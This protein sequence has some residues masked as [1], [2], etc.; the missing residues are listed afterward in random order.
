[1]LRF[2]IKS[3]VRSFKKKKGFYILNISGL[4]IG[5]AASL[6]ILLFV[7]DEMSYDKFHK[8]HERV[9]RIVKDF[10]NDDGSRLPDATTPPALSI[11]IQKDIPEIAKTTRVFP[12]WGNKF[13]IRYGEKNFIEERLWRVDSSFFDVFTFPFIAG[14][15]KKAFN[16]VNSIVITQSMSKKYFGNENAI[17]KVLKLDRLGDLMVT[18]IVNDVP[19]N[20]HFHFDFLIPVKKFNGNINSNWGFYNFYTYV[21]LKPKTRIA[22]V[23]PKIQATYQK[24]VS[25]GK[26]IFYA[27]ALDDI[28]LTSNLKWEIEPN[29]DKMYIRIFSL[30][31]LFVIIIACINY[32]N[33]TTAKSSLRA[34]EIGIR[35]VAGA[36]RLSLIKQ[37]LSESLLIVLFAFVVGIFIAQLLMPVVDQLTNK[38]LSLTTFLTVKWISIILGSVLLLG[39]TAG[40][41]PAIYLSS[42]KPVHVLKGNTVSETKVFSLRKALVVL[43]F[44]ISVVLIIGTVIIIQQVNFI[45]NAKLG[46]NKEQV[47]IIGNANYL[48]RQDLAP[49]Q[50]ELLKID[51]VKSAAV[52]DGVVGGL[53]WTT[54]MNVKG[55]QTQQLVNLLNV[56][57]D[58]LKTLGITIKQGRDFSASYPA[59]SS[60]NGIPGTTER[61][62]GSIILNEKAVKDL[63]IKEPVVGSLVSIG[64]N[65]DTTYYV[66]VVG[67]TNDFHFASFKNEIKPFAFFVDHTRYSNIT[68]KLSSGDLKRTIAGVEKTWAKFSPDKPFQYSFLDDTFGKLYASEERFN[69]VFLYVTIL[70]IFIACLGLFGLTAF[71]IERRTKEI[72]IRKI[73]GASVSGIIVLLSKDFIKL[74][75]ISFIIACPIAWYFMDQW[76]HDFVYRININAWVFVISGIVSVLIAMITI[77]FQSIRAARVNPVESLRTE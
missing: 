10:V 62:S 56:G 44:T 43:Q 26:N 41:Y 32:I 65:N 3:A 55:S 31:G 53:N 24:N 23:V 29:S 70:A 9:Y 60:S 74:V 8:D 75:L 16:E 61:M 59:D 51:G 72:G 46:L 33:L 38:A 58:Y 76:L 1:M 7:I 67:V 28:H 54:S 42:F 45:K 77:S 11:A 37:F 5:L 6:L 39:L 27:Q 17:G 34:K 21:T 30:I 66:T 48:Q 40:I 49:I 20:S 36:V 63:G 47:L 15:Q 35:K 18:G 73:I 71:M 64:T 22:Q 52:A 2:Y 50:N 13:M 69:K 19:A 25:A 68:I 14:D 57:Y 12:N 4:A